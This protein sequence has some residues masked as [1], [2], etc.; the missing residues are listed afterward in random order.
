MK[1]STLES[2]VIELSYE[3]K[4][5]HIGSCLSVLPIFQNIYLDKKPGDVVILS[6]GHAHLAHLVVKEA[7]EK[8]PAIDK[9]LKKHGIH[10]DRK[11]GCDV[12][13]GSLGHGLGIGL[14]MALADP[15][16]T[17][18]VII[19]DG[20]CMEGSVWESLRLLDDLQLPNINVHFNFNGW[21]A[22]QPINTDG[23]IRRVKG[24]LHNPV[25]IMAHVKF[26]R[27]ISDYGPLQGQDAHY[28]VLTKEEYGELNGQA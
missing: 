7:Y 27:S 10:C 28:H 21:G 3:N 26:W 20:E 14:G 4:L 18:H 16:K 6:A 5:S 11:A 2:R 8:M 22:Y 24:F 13:T 17:V 12:S 25:V 9:V 23:L 1:L 19:S 15:S